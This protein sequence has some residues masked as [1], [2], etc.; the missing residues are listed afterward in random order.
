MRAWLRRHYENITLGEINTNV[1]R[2]DVALSAVLML[3]S[4]VHIIAVTT[5]ATEHTMHWPSAQ[6]AADLAVIGFIPFRRRWPIWCT[7]GALVTSTLWMGLHRL[8]GDAMGPGA[9]YAQP[10]T[11]ATAFAMLVL[12]YS[13]FRW[14]PAEQVWKAW[15]PLSLVVLNGVAAGEGPLFVVAGQA[16]LNWGFVF[17]VAMAVRYRDTLHRHRESEIRLAERQD[18]A[19]EL[20]DVVAHYVSAIAVQAQAGQAVAD[21]NPAAAVASLQNIEETASH[22]LLE[23]RRMVGILRAHDDRAP[24]VGTLTLQDLAQAPGTPVVRLR[25]AEALLDDVPLAVNAALIRIAQ[26]SITNARRHGTDAEPI[27]VVVSS[28][29]DQISL[30]ITNSAKNSITGEG[31]GL[32]GMNER[33]TSLGG[34]IL[35]GPLP[36]GGW[37]VNAQIP[38]SPNT[39][40]TE[41]G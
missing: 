33:A 40:T 13:A 38:L 30:V 22:T 16:L 12:G 29:D 1:G 8:H 14:M 34:T 31:F 4:I 17:A 36:H 18:L 24:M 32:I 3:M 20:H 28:Y 21:V 9:D 41:P 5:V 27:D 37:R 19:R 7:T 15:L 11:A 35:A 10:I 6:I 39:S 25:G 23:M 26:E 2:W